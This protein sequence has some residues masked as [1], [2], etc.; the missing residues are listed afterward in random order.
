MSKQE[1]GSVMNS[2]KT[3]PSIVLVDDERDLLFTASHLLASVFPNQVVSFSESSKL[4][5]SYT[6]LTL[7]TIL[8][9]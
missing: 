3:F 4:P 7:P 5:V 2:T 6:H 9:V 8:R 1:D